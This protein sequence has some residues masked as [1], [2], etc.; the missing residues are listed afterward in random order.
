[1]DRETEGLL[2]AMAALNVKE[3]IILTS[4][5]EEVRKSGKTTIII[6]P[7]WKWLLEGST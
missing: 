2:E 1:M 3:G 5:Q 6:K 4:D 7:V